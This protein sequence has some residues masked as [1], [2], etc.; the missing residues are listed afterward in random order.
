MRNGVI[1]FFVGF[2]L[3]VIFIHFYPQVFG[4]DSV[5]RI[6]NR[7]HVLL[8]YQ[9]P[10]LQ[11]VVYAVS[12][13]GGELAA[14]RYAMAV[15]GAFAGVSF[16]LLMRHFADQTKAFW[17]ALLFATNPFLMQL[18]IVPYQEVLMLGLVLLAFH[19]YCAGN[20]AGASISLGLACLTRYEAWAAFPVLAV[21]QMRRDGWSLRPLM[22]YG[23]G[24][25]TWIL[26][27]FG[28]SPQGTFVT[29]SPRSLERLYRYLYLA[30]IVLK[31]VQ[32]PAFV[33]AAFGVVLCVKQ[34]I[35]KRPQAQI[36]LG[37]V[38]LFGLSIPF[39]AH[40][41]SP[42]PER[43]VTAR[44]AAILVCSLLLLAGVGIAHMRRTGVLLAI[45]GAIWGIWMGQRFLERDTTQPAL[46]LSYSLARFL[47]Q[48]MRPSDR[49]VILTSEPSI[50]MYLNKVRTMSG[51]EGIRIAMERMSRM[52]TSPPDFQRT[53]IHSRLARDRFR[54]N[55]SSGDAQ[56]LAIWSNFQPS[57]EWQR[58]LVS[59]VADKSPAAEMERGSL[60]V[61]V[62]RLP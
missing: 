12:K 54:H 27:H 48:S 40:G 10:L 41:E 11:S 8:S 61:R 5:L 39:S 34:Q 31:N 35:W 19:F 1:V 30:W 22:L 59:L 56:W 57:S 46:Q 43:F 24:P 6:M 42:N 55:Q 7:D 4:G 36:V 38:V 14:I 53:V 58:R 60:S 47:D 3:R 33:L 52:D 51:E 62:Y 9:L 49:A 50:D 26:F 17:A 20:R 18:S 25:A 28:L 32:P 2:V 13:A 37:F 16:F 29:E 45:A 21:V 15:I 23:W 44:T